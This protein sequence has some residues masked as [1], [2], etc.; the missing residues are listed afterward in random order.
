MVKIYVNGVE[1]A[2]GTGYDY[3]RK[4]DSSKED[5]FDGPV[6]EQG[7][8]ATFTVKVSR[9]DTYN[10]QYETILRNAILEH[11]EGIPITVV[12]GEVKDIFTGCILES[13]AVKRDPKSKRKIDFSFMARTHDEGRA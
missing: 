7:D 5:T 6:L 8:Y 9:I 2:R 12:D 4:Y 3:D 10:S 11:P 1:F 13:M